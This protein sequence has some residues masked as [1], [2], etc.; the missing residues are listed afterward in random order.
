MRRRL[1]SAIEQFR[2]IA[3]GC[4]RRT[5]LSRAR[6][7]AAVCPRRCRLES[8]EQRALLSIGAAADELPPASW[9]PTV[10][11][12][13]FEQ[14]A[15][16][17]APKADL[18]PG[19]LQL[20]TE[21]SG[22][23]TVWPDESTAA[24]PSQWVVQLTPEATYLA[25]DVAGAADLLES[26]PFPT[27]VICGLGLQG[28]V[29]LQSDPEVDLSTV[30]AW[31]GSNPQVAYAEPNAVLA[32]EAFPNDDEFSALWGLHNTGQ[33][34]GTSDADID[35]P[36]AWELTTG[37][38]SIVVGVIDTGV[39]YTHPDLAA[40][41]WTNPGE[42][43]SNGIDD[44]G[45]GFVDDVHG[46]DFANG[47]GD[48]MDDNGHGTHVSGTIAAAGDNGQGITG[49]N[50]NGSVM[51]LKFLDA[52]GNGF[53]SAAVQALN[54][55][56]M[57]RS[58]YAVSIRVTNN[59]WG[60]GAYSQ[61]LHDAIQASGDAG[62]LFV[63][64][65]GNDGVDTDQSPHYPSGYDLPNVVA[66]T[67]TDHNDG[68]ASFSNYGAASV[69]LAAPGAS[70]Y[71]TLPGGGYGTYSGSSMAAPHVS[72]VAALAWSAVPS[73]SAEQIR[74]AIL[75]GVDP[76]ASLNGRV[77]TGG[78]L[79]ARSTLEELSFSVSASS[80][81]AESIVSGAPVDFTV[82]FSHAYDPLT[83]DA[84]DLMVNG[85]P[86][87]RATPVD[88]GTVSFQF[89]TTPA[90]AEGPQVMEIQ[91]GT[92]LRAG[93]ADPISAWQATFYY[94]ALALAVISATPPEGAVESA[95]P[96][97]IVLHFNEPVDPQSVDVDDLLLSAGWVT[98]ATM[99]DDDSVAYSTSGLP[100]DGEVTYTLSEQ[101]IRDT[102]GTPGPAYVGRFTIDDP[103]IERYAAEDV[104]QS[105]TDH[106]T[107]ISRLTIEESY[108]VADLDV[109]LR[110]THTYDADLDVYLVAPNGTRIAMF[111]GVGGAGDDFA[112]T[113]LDDEADTAI[114]DGEAPFTGRYR[115]LEPLSAM[116]G[117]DVLGTWTL[118]VGDHGSRD[119]G[120]LHGWAL[121]AERGVALPPRIASIDP[122]PADGDDAWGTL[123]ILDIRFS[124]EMNPAS[125]NHADFWELLEAGPDGLFDSADDVPY[126]ITVSPPYVDGMTAA[127]EIGAGQLPVGNYRLTVASGGL[128]SLSGTA[129]DGNGDGTG[130]DDYVTHFRL[131]PADWYPS[132]NVPKPINDRATVTSTL[133][134]AESFP[135][136]DL[137]VKIDITHSY[138]AD[139][140]VY[141][142]APNGIRIELFTDVGGSGNDFAGT[143][144][145]DEADT[146]VIDGQ[147]PFSGRFRPEQP[148]SILDGLDAQGT[149]TLEVTDDNAIDPGTLNA[150]G[151]IIEREAVIPPRIASVD[152]LPPDGG[153]ILGPVDHFEAHFSEAMEATTVNNAGHWEL[154]GAGA[155]GRL[156]TADDVHYPLTVTPAYASGLTATLEPSVERL[157]PDNYRFTA[158][159]SG[160]SDLFGTPLDGDSD[161]TGGDDY[162]THFTVL[163][164]T[165]YPSAD[166]PRNLADFGT[167]TSTLTIDESFV[168]ADLNVQISIS[169]TYDSDLD[170]YLFAPDFTRIELFTDVGGSGDGFSGLVLDDEAAT[171]ITQG[172]APFAGRYRPEGLLSAVDGSNAL[173]TWT[174]EV[175]DD[176][177]LDQG[178]LESWTLILERASPADPPRIV[179]HLPDG[180]AVGPV[181]A[182]RV[183][184]DQPMNQSSF[185]P[186]EDVLSFIG[187]EGPISPMGYN[188][189]DPQTLEILFA[190]Q[191]AAGAYTIVV[192]PQILDTSGTPLDQDGDLFA[193][194]TPD[195]Q[196]TA[197]FTLAQPLGTVAFLDLDGLDPSAGELWYQLQTTRQGVLTLEAN[198][199]VGLGNVELALYADGVSGSP[200]AVSIPTYGNRRIDRE[201]DAPGEVYYLKLSGDYS[202]VDLRLANVLSRDGTTVTVFATDGEDRFEFETS[203]ARQVAINGLR[204]EFETTEVSSVTFLGGPGDEAILYGSDPEEVMEMWPNRG[205]LTR[206]GY[207]VAI[208]GAESITARGGAV[209]HL[210]DSAES[211]TF[212]ATPGSA[213]LS[214]DGFS[215][216]AELFGQVIA[217]ATA[218]SGDVASLYD[219]ATGK[220]TFVAKPDYAEL[221]GEGFRNRAES[222]DYV[223]GFSTLGSGDVA[224]LY[225]DPDGVDTFKAWPDEAKLYG[226]GFY[227]RVKSFRYVHAYATEGNN[228]VAVLYDNPGG[229]DTLKAWPTEA[230]LY[231]DGFYNRAKSFRYVHAFA[232]ADDGDVARLYDDPIGQDTLKAWP[233][234]ARLYG[235][236]FFNRVKS[237][238]SV[239]AYATPGGDDVARLYDDPAGKDT[240]EAWPEM[241]QLVGNGF[242]NQV[243]SFRYVNAYSTP[244]HEDLALLHASAG[245]DTFEAWPHEAWLSGAGFSNRVVSFPRV[246][247]YATEGGNDLARLFDSALDD[248]LEAR[249]NWAR[250][251]NAGL[252]FA[253]LAVAFETVEATSSNEGD[254][255]DIDPAVDFLITHD[256]WQP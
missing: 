67:A 49:V 48:P 215:N 57:M 41:V 212:I 204:Y 95:P 131:L 153:Q 18:P 117:L 37:S 9:T 201:V 163:P 82:Q 172:A 111:S 30:E 155:D 250:L 65:A 207:T 118:E 216:R 246:E 100:R 29:L 70:I 63:A 94:D 193:G 113:I 142:I 62:V 169:H 98:A 177:A 79:N 241:A 221:Y 52:Q 218:G 74:T 145:D 116:D 230:K 5:L 46:Y 210:Y 132:G 110:I 225:D 40:N 27:Q 7:S 19:P 234:E 152:P 229:R 252:A 214:G 38:A 166:V 171:S 237:F 77:A 217:Y 143:V 123:D 205:T 103:T 164:G 186:T 54:Y 33:T 24:A 59:S 31:L 2:A 42:V 184:F 23:R 238:H 101:A 255:K 243:T 189:L 168:I 72:G 209:A 138:D 91:G 149:W 165:Q 182:V 134:V 8:L 228:D 78:R 161:G 81:A 89:D 208:E 99:L 47:D 174:L 107:V 60:G 199:Q 211:D 245:Q 35:A 4:L 85:I 253:N 129:L 96:A 75:E 51:A 157:P 181:E 126:A 227:Y 43:P 140:D 231:G 223:Y 108:A 148:F 25:G 133:T 130:G 115:P 135:I 11:V 159:G 17:P 144:L 219:N 106:S 222:F 197:S 21:P 28:M 66:V 87:D 76:V 196:Y 10:D 139:L 158:L 247:A 112:A 232:T 192:A 249:D 242:R 71:S 32:T 256:L 254:T 122:L 203:T 56:T 200:V 12:A 124:K 235:D 251:S 88:V 84:A 50:W 206:N 127:L 141:L 58:Q 167:I 202:D 36:E 185:S 198:F 195:D 183:A 173:G 83:L 1:S 64:A 119:Q 104:P 26:S 233:N 97:E 191:Q 34:G 179:G 68:L 156:D 154:T 160:L 102:H 114:T 15:P 92:I 137:D 39:D 44:D 80:P 170:V 16:A 220:D 150:W 136:A 178:I 236:G 176:A 109:E 13:W 239:Y 120:I 93:D 180:V 240:F 55:A 190:P 147:S 86:A 3:G 121:V 244:G 162:V 226:D 188:W 69:D 194:E 146:A 128:V 53:T 224:L 90:T 125:V 151:I 6:T 45:N 20:E 105:I 248:L 14:L 187:P 61:A 213:T 22:P 175:T 73:A